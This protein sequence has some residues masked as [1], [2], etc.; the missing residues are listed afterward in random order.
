MAVEH[1]I[2]E[3]TK[4]NAIDMLVSLI[5]EELTDD[6]NIEPDEAFSE[7]ISSKTGELLYDKDSKLWWNGPSYIVELYKDEM[8]ETKKGLR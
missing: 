7:F 2:T 5:V 8:K 6:L 1:D 4:N 3:E